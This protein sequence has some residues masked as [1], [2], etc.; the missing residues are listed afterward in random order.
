MCPRLIPGRFA[1]ASGWKRDRCLSPCGIAR[2]N[3]PIIFNV[4]TAPA[5]S[6]PPV[7]KAVRAVG[8]LKP[9]FQPQPTGQIFLDKLDVRGTAFWLRE[10]KIAITCAHVVQDLVAA[11]LEVAGLLV[12]GNLGN[13]LRAMIGI[14]DYDHDLAVLRLAPDTAPEL[15]AKEAADGLEIATATPGVGSPVAYAGFPFGTQ[16]LSSTHSPTYAEG[17]IAS[18]VR[19]QPLRKEIQITGTVAGGFSG[20]AIVDKAHPNQVVAVLSNSPS[21][22]V[23]LANIFMGISWEHLIRLAQLANS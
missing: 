7:F 14:V 1:T 10:Y 12:L 15:A 16:L 20:A 5:L 2:P 17:L 9:K 19:A 21:A 6:Q 22:E 11:P 8:V 4:V 13:Y 18:T 3:K 23:G